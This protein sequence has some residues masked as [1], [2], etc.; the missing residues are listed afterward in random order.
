MFTLSQIRE[1]LELERDALTTTPD[2][3]YGL[4]KFTRDDKIEIRLEERYTRPGQNTIGYMETI[5]RF[6][7]SKEEDVF[8]AIYRLLRNALL[9]ERV[10]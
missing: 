10:Q 3:Q 6:F 7:I 8:D 5:L 9:V 4:Y 1:L 2:G